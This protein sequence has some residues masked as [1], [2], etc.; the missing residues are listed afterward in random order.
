MYP[1]RKNS[2]EFFCL[3]RHTSKTVTIHGKKVIDK[4]RVTFFSATVVPNTYSCCKYLT[5]VRI[6]FQM[7]ANT[8]QGLQVTR[9]L[10]SSDIKTGMGQYILFTFHVIKFDKKILSCNPKCSKRTKRQQF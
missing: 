10:M 7:S 4:T 6:Q 9:P 3:V 2:D 5:H 8:H 1:Y